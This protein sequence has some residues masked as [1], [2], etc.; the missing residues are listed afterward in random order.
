MDKQT[1]K[2]EIVQWIYDKETH[3]VTKRLMR[4][5]RRERI[6]CNCWILIV[7]LQKTY[8]DQHRLTTL[9]FTRKFTPIIQTYSFVDFERLSATNYE[10]KTQLQENILIEN[11]KKNKNKY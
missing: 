7:N 6:K 2:A 11:Y 8:Y 9:F 5:D 3:Q 1:L 10:E 4:T